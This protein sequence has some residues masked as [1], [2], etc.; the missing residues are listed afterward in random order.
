MTHFGSGRPVRPIPTPRET[1]GR[2]AFG[3]LPPGI[4]QPPY[5]ADTRLKRARHHVPPTP[6]CHPGSAAQLGC[7]VAYHHP[8]RYQWDQIDELDHRAER[9]FESDYEGSDGVGESCAETDD[10]AQG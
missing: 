1:A 9:R 4:A 7:V 5:S 8:L 2:L 10:E 3:D 6:H